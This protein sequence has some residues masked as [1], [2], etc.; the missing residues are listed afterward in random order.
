MN[1]KLMI[2]IST[3]GITPVMATKTAATLN[4]KSDF[5]L[6]LAYRRKKIEAHASTSRVIKMIHLFSIKTFNA[7][8]PLFF[9]ILSSYILMPDSI[10]LESFKLHGQF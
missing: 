9:R 1:M 5:K 2:P 3:W 6:Y 7:P 4:Q 10:Q 8:Q